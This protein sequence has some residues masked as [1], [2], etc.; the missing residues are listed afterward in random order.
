MIGDFFI[1][2]HK[3]TTAI[4]FKNNEHFESYIFNIDMDYYAVDTI[5]TGFFHKL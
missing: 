3:Q 1:E 2:E 5:L 4:R